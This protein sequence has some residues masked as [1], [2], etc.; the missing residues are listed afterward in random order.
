MLGRSASRW[1]A[2][3]ILFSSIIWLISNATAC[4]S[5]T[6]IN[7]GYCNGITNT[8]ICDFD[9]GDCCLPEVNLSD[10]ESA[11]CVC[12]EDGLIHYEPIY[13]E[14][15]VLGDDICDD[16]HNTPD[17]NFDGGDCCSP[18]S[19]MTY[20]NLCQCFNETNYVTPP[21]TVKWVGNSESILKLLA[22]N[23]SLKFY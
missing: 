23:I 7:N 14:V 2:I 15:M 9:G 5:W 16:T 10:C 11:E 22:H 18:S 13:C 4:W 3:L 19:I 6:N 17:C 8:E 12:H 21:T 20:C 1:F